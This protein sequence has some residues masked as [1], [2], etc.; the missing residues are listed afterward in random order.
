[1]KTLKFILTILFGIFMIAGGVNHFLTPESYFRLIP[2][3]FP[4]AITNYLAGVVEIALG[5]G[6]FIP[7]VRNLSTKGI[8]LLM[9]IFLPLHVWDVFRDDPAIGSHNMAMIRLPVQFIFIL[10]A[11]FI[12]RAE[13]IGLPR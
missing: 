6:V 12:S 5:I 1:M 8:L 3:F 9:F 7:G 4:K 11:W 10:W 2:D 13:V